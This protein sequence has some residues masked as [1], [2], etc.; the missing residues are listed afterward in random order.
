M[1]PPNN[2]PLHATSDADS[3]AFWWSKS[4]YAERWVA[5]MEKAFA[6]RYMKTDIAATPNICNIPKGDPQYALYVLMGD[7]HWQRFWN[8]SPGGGAT[9]WQNESG[10][11]SYNTTTLW[12]LLW[13]NCSSPTSALFR[14]TKRP[15]VAFTFDSGAAAPALPNNGGQPQYTSDLLVASHSYSLLGVYN[16]GGTLGTN[17]KP[18]GGKNYVVLRNPWGVISGVTYE[19]RDTFLGTGRSLAAGPLPAFTSTGAKRNLWS[20]TDAGGKLM[21]GVFAVDMDTFAR[22]F[23]GFSW[24]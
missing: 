6:I 10:T 24:A 14:K 17:D 5:M 15:S 13:I 22:Y 19:Y 20:K 12:N 23:R 11:V 21:D 2:L 4:K 1:Y 8:V 16:E 3:T 7:E 9:A 18:A